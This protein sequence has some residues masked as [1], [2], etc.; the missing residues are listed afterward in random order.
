MAQEYLTVHMNSVINLAFIY[1]NGNEQ[2]R[3]VPVLAL[4]ALLWSEENVIIHSDNFTDTS[5]LIFYFLD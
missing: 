1:D 2:I 3:D 5:L 4:H